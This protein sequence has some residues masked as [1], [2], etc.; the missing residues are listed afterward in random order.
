MKV[1][2]AVDGSVYTRKMLSYLTRF[3]ALMAEAN[4]L[5][6]LHVQPEL[7]PRANAAT[8]GL[9]RY[10]TEQAEKILNPVVEKLA[11]S[12]GRPNAVS[13][14]GPAGETIAEY[15]KQERFD[16][17]V[18]GSH[19]ASAL[20]NVVMGSAATKVLAHCKIPVLLVR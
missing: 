13:K 14:S 1:L 9:R 18:M 17:V 8:D 5:T 2:I 19:G 15:A 12:Y 11:R 7:G 16:L 4:A 6:V 10:Q 20:R 3:P